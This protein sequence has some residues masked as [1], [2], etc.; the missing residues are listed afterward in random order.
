M[1]R[2]RL[3][4]LIRTVSSKIGKEKLRTVK[5]KIQQKKS[6]DFIKKTEEL[7][8]K[9]NLLNWAVFFKYILF[10]EINLKDNVRVNI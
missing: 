2:Q 6:K 3:K 10:T 4:P 8:K 5:L 9:L 7:T 1:F